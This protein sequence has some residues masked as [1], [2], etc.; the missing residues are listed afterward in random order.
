MRGRAAAHQGVAQRSGK[1]WGQLA[2]SSGLHA[3]CGVLSPV[4]SAQPLVPSALCCPGQV[5]I[6]AGSVVRIWDSLERVLA[7]HEL[8]LK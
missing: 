7:K 4:H 6:L 8:E 5:T 2:P 1:P 3:G